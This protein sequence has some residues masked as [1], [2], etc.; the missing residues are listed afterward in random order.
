MVLLKRLEDAVRDGDTWR[1]SG[2]KVWT[3]RGHYSR[4]GLL[5]G[6]TLCLTTL[7]IA[8]AVANSVVARGPK[9]RRSIPVADFVNGPFQTVLASRSL[10][11]RI[12]TT[13]PDVT[14]STNLGAWVNRR[15]LFARESLA[16]TF[17]Q[18]RIPST[19]TWD[20]SPKGQHIELG[21][22]EM[23]LF[24]MLSAL[25]L[26]HAINGERLLPVGTL[27]DPFIER[28]LDAMNMVARQI[29]RTF[30]HVGAISAA[31]SPV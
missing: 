14:V 20:F 31:I 23:N 8:A 18:E 21:I 7:A 29:K 5:L 9:G 25:G 17:R 15:G 6:A 28:G 12:V 22:A 16:D 26:S 19:F 27:Y 30:A 3:S 4:R 2:S 11:E 24:I 1:V 10:A 13:S